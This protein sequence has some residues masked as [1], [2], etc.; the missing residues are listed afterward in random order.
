MSLSGAFLHG[1]GVRYDLPI[2]LA[3]YLYAAAGVV[4][5]SFVMVAVFTGDRLGEK[6]VRYPSRPSPFLTR[7]DRSP[8]SRRL[9]G[10]IGV[11]ALGAI[12]VTGLFGSSNPLVSPAEYLLWVYFW[13]GLVILTGLAG[14]LWEYL[15]PFAAL[16]GLLARWVQPPERTL[17]PR[18]GIWPA[19]VLYFGFAFFELA[20]GVSNQ[21]A[22]VGGLCLAYTLVTVAGMLVFGRDAWLGEVEFITILFDLVGRFSP[23]ERDERGRLRLRPWGVG[24]LRPYPAGWDRLAFIILTLSTLAF[25]GITATQAYQVTLTQKLEP[26]WLPYGNLGFAIYK[27]LSLLVLTCVFLLVFTIFARLV[28]Y[29]GYVRVDAM[30]TMTAFALTLVPIALVYNAAHNYTYLVIQSQGLPMA[31]QHTFVSGP[32][33]PFVASFALANAA[34][35]WY[36]QVVLIVIGHV[37]AVYLA[38]LRAGERFRTARNALL[39]QYPM[40]ILMVGYTMTSLWILAQ[41]TTRG[42]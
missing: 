22:L 39:S 24:L 27:G 28:I 15:S 33:P 16:H 18:L 5:I 34:I 37:I 6:A 30:Q 9:G 20:S 35:V 31:F 26:L 10:A 4:V 32:P 11:L 3:L 12:V 40:L 8:W 13:A 14:N 25:D 23:V 17:P 29:F 21:P 19:V 41:P 42:G 36:V 1:F 38:H 2:S 7:L